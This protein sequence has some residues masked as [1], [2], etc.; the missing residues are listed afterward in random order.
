MQGV[1]SKKLLIYL[2]FPIFLS[3]YIPMSFYLIL[4]SWSNVNLYKESFLTYSH[5]IF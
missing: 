3:V 1:L 2:D 5:V 4:K